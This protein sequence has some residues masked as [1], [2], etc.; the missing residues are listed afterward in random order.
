MKWLGWWDDEQM[1]R[2]ARW[3]YLGRLN[4]RVDK[5]IR[6]AEMIWSME[7]SMKRWSGEK[8]EWMEQMSQRNDRT[9]QTTEWRK[10]SRVGETIESIHMYM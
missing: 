2:V 10:R 7:L 1:K 9:V 6:V 8:I 4:D 3:N 5:R